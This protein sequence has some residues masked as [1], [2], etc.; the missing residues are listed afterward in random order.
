MGWVQGNSLFYSL[1]SSF[2]ERRK[3]CR[4]NTSDNI[5]QKIIIQFQIGSTNVVQLR[6]SEGQRFSRRDKEENEIH[7][8]AV[9]I[10]GWFSFLKNDISFSSSWCFIKT[11][12][13]KLFYNLIQGTGFS[14]VKMSVRCKCQKKNHQ[15]ASQIFVD[16]NFLLIG[17]NFDFFAS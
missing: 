7:K 4:A 8:W 2:Q 11:H 10:E 12:G 5:V 3:H 9:K 17:L 14:G 6:D 1:N 15:W 13:R 16:N